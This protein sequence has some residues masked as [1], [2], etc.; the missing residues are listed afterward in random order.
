M[1]ARGVKSVD[2]SRILPPDLRR[3]L[4]NLKNKKPEHEIKVW[5]APAIPPHTPSTWKE[6]RP[7]SFE[8]LVRKCSTSALLGLWSTPL[9]GPDKEF[10]ALS[11]SEGFSRDAENIH[12]YFKKALVALNDETRR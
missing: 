11:I 4:D 7:S 8:E 5:G 10:P 9:P 2:K 12:N 6:P 3:L 1:K